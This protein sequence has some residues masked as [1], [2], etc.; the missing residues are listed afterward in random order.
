MRVFSRLK[1]KGIAKTYTT[2]EKG[3]LHHAG[4]LQV[5][6]LVE[7]LMIDH[8]TVCS[9][10]FMSDPAWVHRVAEGLAE[11][12]DQHQELHAAALDHDEVLF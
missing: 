9:Q 7:A 11:Q 1:N 4:I 2:V 5:F 3:D 12:P 6:S 8:L 10:G